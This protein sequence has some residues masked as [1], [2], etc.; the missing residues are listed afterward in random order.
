[1]LIIIA[2][3]ALTVYFAVRN[4]RRKKTESNGSAMI[5][6]EG[7]KEVPALSLPISV[8]LAGLFLYAFWEAIPWTFTV[9]LFPQAVATVGGLLAIST[10]VRD[11]RV[12]A[13]LRAGT[14]PEA[15]QYADVPLLRRGAY[16]LLWL[17]GVLLVTLALGQ[18]VTL[19]L[20]VALYLKF[21]GRFGWKMISIYTI[22]SAGFLY[23][24]FNEIVPV[25]WHESP[26]FSV[27]N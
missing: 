15:V 5:T 7:G 25:M 9:K 17:L 24:L 3:I 19:L 6:G 20:F 26:W 13:A 14:A 22:A 1:V 16:F 21:W 11:F 12:N 10:V 23:L 8:A 2:L 27:L 18:F 4:Q